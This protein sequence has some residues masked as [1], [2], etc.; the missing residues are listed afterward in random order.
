MAKD[1]KDF[2][3]KTCFSSFARVAAG[4]DDTPKLA[5]AS[6][7][8]L[9]KLLKPEIGSIIENNKDILTIISN[10]LLVGH[11]N[12]NGDAITKKDALAIYNNFK[13]K[14]LDIQHNKEDVA[15][16]I[17]DSGFSKFPSSV[18]IDEEEARNT[19]GPIQLVISAFLWKIINPDLCSFLIS[20]SDESSPDYGAVS[21]SFEL[22]FDNYDIVIGR[23]G[24][25]NIE[26]GELITKD[27][28]DFEKFDHLLTC[29][30]GPGKIGNDLVGRILRDDIIPI[31]AGLVT[32][33]ASGLK[34]MLTI[35]SKE[36]LIDN[37]DNSVASP[38]KD[39]NVELPNNDSKTPVTNHERLEPEA[40]KEFLKNAPQSG[41]GSVLQPIHI[42]Q[43]KN[44]PESGMGYQFCD[45]EMNDGSR[46]F[47]K[48]LNCELVEA[49][50]NT[51]DIKSI[52]LHQKSA[53]AQNNNIN[54]QN[55]SKTD[56]NT[57]TIGVNANINNKIEPIS[58]NITIINMPKIT[59]LKQLETLWPELVKSEAVASFTSVRE[60]IE[61][62]LAKVSEVFAKQ[63]ADKDN[64]AKITEA[65]KAEAETRSNELQAAVDK[66]NKHVE[67]LKAEEHVRKSGEK[68][69][70]RMASID[71]AFDLDE[72]SR[73]MLA[74]EV[75][76]MPCEAEE[77]DVAYA[78]WLDKHKKLMKEKTKD[79]KKEQQD[80]AEASKK[81]LEDKLAKAGL[82]ATFDEKT[83]DVKEVVASLKE[84]KNQL[85]IPNNVEAGDNTTLTQ[86][87]AKAFSTG[88]VIGGKTA[89]QLVKENQDKA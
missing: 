1:L 73:A 89:G 31:G 63:L 56:I 4:N 45:I 16:C 17:Y 28:K 71:C 57:Q 32:K 5:V 64:I 86:K 25:T 59:D 81:L 20:A 75:R 46:H 70:E 77:D 11:V 41:V 9:T 67:Q 34:G 8:E 50:I 29:N 13:Y 36:D 54:N 48:V 88:L 21:T 35:V 37:I 3:Y 68:F 23:N 30:D 83:L 26:E 53:I 84:D 87:F 65:N 7:K 61:G 66:L 58:N 62:E 49:K 85:V 38:N 43:L 74:S 15:G 60:F 12:L 33:P 14:Y 2:R 72:D 10:L 82:K 42:E 79:F 19:N 24:N 40:T 51:N 76:S 22:L 6:I 18:I 55:L 44:E 69:N 47:V 80:K 27:H 78:A 52:K 39:G